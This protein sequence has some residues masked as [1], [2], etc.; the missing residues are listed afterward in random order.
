MSVMMK[1]GSYHFS[2]STSA[3]Q[4]FKHS[5]SYRWHGQERL[6]RTAAY[7]YLGVGAEQIDLEGTIYPHFKGGFSQIAAM[8][9]TADKVK[10]LL[11]ID[12]LGVSWGNWVI[13]R[14]EQGQEVFLKNGQPR[15]ITFRLTLL[16]YGEDR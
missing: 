15:K 12:G 1:L 11:L 3:Y 2:L 13:T 10:P 7:Q 5:V 4:K 8:R 16:K 9:R 6:Q 14:L